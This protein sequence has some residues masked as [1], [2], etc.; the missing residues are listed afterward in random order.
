VKNL[1]CFSLIGIIGMACFISFSA[2]ADDVDEGT[3]ADDIYGRAWIGN[4]EYHNSPGNAYVTT[5]HLVS[6]WHYNERNKVSF[7]W[8][9]KLQ[10]LNNRSYRSEVS[11]G[12]SL[13]KFNPEID[14]M[15]VPGGASGFSFIDVTPLPELP[16]DQHYTAAG[17]TRISAGPDVIWK[18][19]DSWIFRR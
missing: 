14:A 4:F 5:D 10:I 13:R 11:G 15:P 16:P 1:R 7:V 8:V 18:A 9:F 3:Q 2:P 19:S 12:E 17:Y 6:Y